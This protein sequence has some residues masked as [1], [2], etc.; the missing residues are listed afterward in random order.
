MIAAIFG[1]LLFLGLPIALVLAMTA[2]AY[3]YISG[4]EVLY[5]SFPQQFFGSMENYGLLA[6]PLF[7]IVGELMNEGGITKRLVALASV[8]IGHVRGGLAY[9]NIL[10][11]M[12]L[13]SIVGSANAQV[14]VMAQVMVPEMEKQ[15]YQRGFATAT[16]CAGALLAPIIPPSMLFV[17]FGVLAQVSIGDMFIA[18]IIPGLLMAAAFIG[19]IAL[20]GWRYNYPPGERLSRQ[21]KLRNITAAI[22]SMLVPA[23]MIGGILGGITTPTEA[24]A[25]GSLAAVLVGVFAHNEIRFERI[26]GMVMRV[27]INSGVVLALVAAAGVFGWV[28]VFEKIPQQLAGILQGMTADPFIFLMLVMVLLLAVGMVLDGIAALILLVPILLPVATQVYGINPY[29]FGVL[30]CI[31]L[32]VGLLTP[33]VGAALYVAA[34]VTGCRPAE[35]IRPLIPFLLATVALLVLLSWQPYLV[36]ALIK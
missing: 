36:T 18:G 34:R 2:L 16:T 15:G 35:I 11:N 32:T 29:H 28:I 5:L 23:L 25:V 30:I 17:I 8:F 22:P 1:V 31:N 13:A 6:I 7:M 3:I 33:P 14:A 10:A 20:L 9:I 12:F 19:V 26:G 27:A 24:A 21:Q 4:N